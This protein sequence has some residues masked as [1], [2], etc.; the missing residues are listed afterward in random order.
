MSDNW[1][2]PERAPEDGS[3]HGFNRLIIA[4]NLR[5]ESG[6]PSPP[7][8]SVVMRSTVSKNLRCKSGTPRW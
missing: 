4:E 5:C 3:V 7:T 1:G 2:E 6:N 8:G